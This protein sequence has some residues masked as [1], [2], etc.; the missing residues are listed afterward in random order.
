MRLTSAAIA[1]AVFSAT[2]LS[3]PQD[4]RFNSNVFKNFSIAPSQGGH[5]ICITGK[6]PVTA[7][8]TKNLNFLLPADPDQFTITQTFLESVQANF[9]VL[10]TLSAGNAEVSGTWDINAKLCYPIGWNPENSSKSIQFLIHG[11]GFDQAYWDF[12]P[13]YSYIDAVALAGYPTFSYD[14]LGT[15]ASSHPDPIQVVQAPLEVEI[16][17]SLIQSLRTSSLS[18]NAFKKVIVVGHSFG[19]VQSVAIAANHPK[20]ADAVVLTGFS[21][22]SSGINIAVADFGLV[23]ASDAEPARFRS[24]ANGYLVTPTA[25]SNQFA[26]FRYPNFDPKSKSPTPSH[27]THVEI[28]YSQYLLQSSPSTNLANKPSPLASSSPKQPSS[29]QPPTSQGHSTSY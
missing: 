13:G 7:S 28:K 12:A 24:L 10:E 29:P 22:E 4:Q 16:A 3:L 26:F 18:K 5:A 25:A 19:S 14:R 23:I 8:T 6:I 1:V 15:G 20:D 21:I 11:L 27:T 2:A 9:S 17:H